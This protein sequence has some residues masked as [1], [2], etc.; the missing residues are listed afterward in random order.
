MN[1]EGTILSEINQ[2]DKVKHCMKSFVCG[3]KI[4]SCCCKSM[5]KFIFLSCFLY[6]FICQRTL[7]LFPCLS[8]CRWTAINEGYRY[9]FEILTSFSLDEYSELEMLNIIVE[10]VL[11]FW[12]TSTLFA[13]EAAPI[14]ISNN[15]GQ[16]SLSSTFLSK[17]FIPC[18]FDS[19]HSGRCKGIA[20]FGFDF[21]F[22]DD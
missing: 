12:G 15:S 8:C 9:L 14:Y 3:L 7:G 6:P 2:A 17:F 19:N 21:H 11:I 13:I 20:L 16:G 22:P 5:K 18:L 10:L 4:H 1:L